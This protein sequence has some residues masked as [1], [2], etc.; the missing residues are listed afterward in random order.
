[1]LNV[2]AILLPLYVIEVASQCPK[3]TT[4]YKGDIMLTDIDTC[5]F[6]SV[7]AAHNFAE[8]EYRAFY[9]F[10]LLRNQIVID[11]YPFIPGE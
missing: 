5:S 2:L 8:I 1:M 10:W 6:R 9:Q 11:S 7:Q 3:N 4:L